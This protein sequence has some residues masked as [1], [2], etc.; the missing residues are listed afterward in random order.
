MSDQKCCEVVQ[1]LTHQGLK[2]TVAVFLQKDA[3]VPF[4]GLCDF[5]TCGEQDH[6]LIYLQNSQTDRKTLQ[7]STEEGSFP[8]DKYHDAFAGFHSS[9]K[10]HYTFHSGKADQSIKTTSVYAV[11]VDEIYPPHSK[12]EDS[13][14]EVGFDNEQVVGSA[15]AYSSIERGQL[16]S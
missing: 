11:W 12:V 13:K 10:S 16:R 9:S 3:K 6:W 5:H 14:E 4:V 1:I 7:Y 2:C 8:Q 15:T